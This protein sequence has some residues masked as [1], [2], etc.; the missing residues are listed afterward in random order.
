[1]RFV[2]RGKDEK[3]RVLMPTAFFAEL[4]KRIVTSIAVLVLMTLM[5]PAVVHAGDISTPKW[6][7]ELSDLPS[8]PSLIYGRFPNGFGYILKVNHEPKDRVSMHLNVRAGSFMETDDQQGVA[9][10]LEHMQFNGSTHFK[11][12]DLVKYFQTIGMQFGPDANAHTGFTETVFDVVLPGGDAESIA[13]GLRVLKDYAEGALLL[14]TEIDRER[15]VILA[16]KRSRDSVDYRTF[17]SALAFELPEARISKRLPIGNDAVLKSVGRERIKSFYDTWYRPEK[18]TLIMVGDFDVDAVIPRIQEAFSAMAAR[19]PALPEPD[20]GQIRH[21]GDKY[22]YHHEPEAGNTSVSIEAIWKE[23]KSNDS[24]AFQQQQLLRNMADSIVQNRLS[25]LVQKPDTPFTSASIRSGQYLEDIAFTEISATCGPD[26]WQASFST[27]EQVLRGAIEHGFTLSELERVKKDFLADLDNGVKQSSTRKSND[28]AQEIIHSINSNRV[29]M[30]PDQEKS[31]FAPFIAAVDVAVVHAAFLKN[32]VRDHR[33]FM[34]TGNARIDS[35]PDGPEA[36]IRS[37]IRE[38]LQMNVSRPAEALEVRFPYIDVPVSEKK[39]ILKQSDIPD[40]GIVQID[41]KN[42]VRLNL[43]K[44]D[45]EADKIR[46]TL[47]FG[48]G[49][50]DEPMQKPGLSVLAEAIVSESGFAGLTKDELG[51][52]LAGKEWKLRFDAAEDR[53][54]FN[55]E[56]PA[57]ELELIF[58]LLYSHLMDPGFRPEAF[59]LATDRFDQM[60]QSLS[61]DIDGAMQLHGQRFLSGGDSRFGLP[62]HERFAQLTLADVK[63]WLL[64]LLKEA[65]LEMSLVG[66]FDPAKAID[67]A[68]TYLGALETRK[69]SGLT[70]RND[71]PQFPFGKALSVNVDTQIPK[72]LIV[73]A[74]PTTDFWDI[75]RTRRLSV[76]GDIFSEKLRETVREKLGVSYSPYAYNRS[77]RAYSGY[78]LLQAFV[79]IDPDKAQMVIDEVKKIGLDISRNGVSTDELARSIE[80]IMTNIKEMRQTNDYWLRSVLVGSREHPEQLDWSRTM[81]S[82]F[83]AITAAEISALARKYLIAEKAAQIVARPV[84]GANSSSTG[85]AVK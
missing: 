70:G 36:K 57:Q 17:T 22:F 75:Q 46:F 60:Y 29:Y 23:T 35:P 19:A 68:A 30:S 38:S 53:F 77:S 12:G 28:L 40:L 83:S 3:D 37:V 2:T 82:D 26:K 56:S 39:N 59:N 4:K 51:R 76:V 6:P 33:L 24:L 71:L 27:I 74:Y 78:G 80:P 85:E 44:T 5:A 48:R 52:A 10:F 25:E 32:W 54:S 45:F 16:E 41:F 58:Q 50:S 14:T 49:K 31:L 9:H 62:S 72:G 66:D 73:V 13:G 84:K 18:M 11:P 63:D 67:L 34:L 65:P 79:Y 42:G 15:G 20:P 47:S 61:R 8:D 1:M 21:Q 43:K 81:L 64:P 7:Q 69:S 55:G